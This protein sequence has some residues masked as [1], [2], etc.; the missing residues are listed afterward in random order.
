[1]LRWHV[2]LGNVAIPKSVH[3]ERIRENAQI[4]DFSLDDDEMAVLSALDEPGR[5]GPDPET[6]DLS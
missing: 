1:V 6:M 5:L 4:F 3:A 2:Q